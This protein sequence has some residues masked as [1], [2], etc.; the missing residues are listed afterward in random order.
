MPH[1]NAWW[2]GI[3]QERWFKK[4]CYII[5]TCL[6][7][8]SRWRPRLNFPAANLQINFFFFFSFSSC[9][10]HQTFLIRLATFKITQILSPEKASEKKGMSTVEQFILYS[11]DLRFRE[12]LTKPWFHQQLHGQKMEKNLNIPVN[13]LF[14]QCQV[15]VKM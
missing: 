6:L 4:Y 1:P 11:L 10:N 5:L 12:L 14:G 15:Y 3:F 7:S 9:H 2:L 13:G 8:L